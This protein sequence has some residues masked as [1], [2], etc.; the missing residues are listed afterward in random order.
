MAMHNYIARIPDN[1]KCLVCNLP[2]IQHTEH[3]ECDVCGVVGKHDMHVLGKQSAVM[4]AD[5]WD[6]EKKAR[7]ENELKKALVTSTNGKLS[8]IDT[9]AEYFNAKVQSIV[10]RKK[11]IEADDSIDKEKK[12]FKLA[13]ELLTEIPTLRDRLFSIREEESRIKSELNAL[14]VQINQVSTELR[15][16]ELEQ[17]KIADINYKVPEQ[18]AKAP[19]ISKPSGGTKKEMDEIS[20]LVVEF[21][22]FKLT[23]E[24]V[25]I[26]A[27]QKKCSPRDAVR[28]IL[29]PDIVK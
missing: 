18:K 25:R 22:Q 28:S 24:I 26:I 21:K 23:R 1:G 20:A 17:L 14:Q 19:R 9:Q 3:A 7:E 11:A 8:M 13:Q 10:E 4:C 6:K 12:P 27:L 15:K 2:E 5:C 29:G 16:E